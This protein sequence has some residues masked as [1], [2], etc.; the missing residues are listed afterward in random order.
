MLQKQLQVK[1]E[2]KY[3]IIMMQCSTAETGVGLRRQN[4]DGC[5]TASD[6][7]VT[8]NIVLGSQLRCLLPHHFA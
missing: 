3:L 5:L 2:V 1:K 8:I 7:P 4:D 6:L